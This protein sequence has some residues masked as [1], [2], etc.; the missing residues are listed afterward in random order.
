MQHAV[1]VITTRPWRTYSGAERQGTS[2]GRRG[3]SPGRHNVADVADQHQG[4]FASSTVGCNRI[5]GNR[6]IATAFVAGQVDPTDRAL[7]A[8]PGQRGS[9]ED[10]RGC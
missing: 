9:P 3:L 8:G 6:A 1:F 5:M 2:A 10:C 7:L 4:P